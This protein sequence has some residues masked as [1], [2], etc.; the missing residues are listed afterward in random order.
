MNPD[1]ND[2]RDIAGLKFNFGQISIHTQSHKS[3]EEYRE[4]MYFELLAVDLG[5]QAR[6]IFTFKKIPGLDIRV[7]LEG[8]ISDRPNIVCRYLNGLHIK[9]QEHDWA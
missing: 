4:C 6:F 7:R 5:R 1:F 3:I 2:V 8:N 9:L